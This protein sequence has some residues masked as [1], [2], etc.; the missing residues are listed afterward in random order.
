MVISLDG[1]L[2]VSCIVR[3]LS[4]WWVCFLGAGCY[5]DCVPTRYCRCSSSDCRPRPHQ[6]SDRSE[7]RSDGR[8][9]V[10]AHGRSRWYST[11]GGVHS[12]TD[13]N[14]MRMCSWNKITEQKVI[15]REFWR[16]QTHLTFSA[17]VSNISINCTCCSGQGSAAR[18]R[19][20]VSLQAAV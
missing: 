10:A 17:S 14:M 20:D 18:H 11:A 6:H 4:Q 5:L 7:E 1:T 8:V 13:A 12:N 16:C 19:P 9:S 3:S 15:S 2:S